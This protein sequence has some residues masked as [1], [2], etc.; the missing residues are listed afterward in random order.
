MI[1]LRGKKMSRQLYHNLEDFDFVTAFAQ[2]RTL[3]SDLKLILTMQPHILPSKDK[4]DLLPL[5]IT[6]NYVAQSR[7]LFKYGVSAYGDGSVYG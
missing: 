7:G 2:R 3:Q 5:T 4:E 6:A 1:N